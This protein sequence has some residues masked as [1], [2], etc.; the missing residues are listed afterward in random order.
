[1]CRNGG[2]S[3]T[4]WGILGQMWKA[5]RSSLL[6][7]WKIMKS[8]RKQAK[9]GLQRA[10]NVRL[11][12]WDLIFLGTEESIWNL[13]Q[14]ECYQSNLKKLIYHVNDRRWMTEGY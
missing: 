11:R 5:V 3:Q 7:G 4:K 12:N 1:M 10:L 8:F 9:A 6:Q 13:D 2:R 14:G